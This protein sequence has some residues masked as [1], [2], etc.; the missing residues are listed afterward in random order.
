MMCLVVVYKQKTYA[1]ENGITNTDELLTCFILIVKNVG[2]RY[3]PPNLQKP[4]E[5]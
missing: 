3:A 4:K 2:Y 5:P 1:K